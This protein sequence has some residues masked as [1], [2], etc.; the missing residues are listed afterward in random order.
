[1][2][3]FLAT[4]I[5]NTVSV[6]TVYRI[7]SLPVRPLFKSL[8]DKAGERGIS[9]KTEKITPSYRR[10]YRNPSEGIVVPVTGAIRLV[11]GIVYPDGTMSLCL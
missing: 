4:P 5:R 11:P 10:I 7:E 1:V 8:M 2:L 6:L 3:S 9:P